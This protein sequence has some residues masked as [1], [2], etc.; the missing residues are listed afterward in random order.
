[1]KLERRAGPR[2]RGSLDFRKAG[3]VV[4]EACWNVDV[5][6]PRLESQLCPPLT[7]RCW[8]CYSVSES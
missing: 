5:H 4:M 7:V 2:W 1:M 8:P 3:S 6:T